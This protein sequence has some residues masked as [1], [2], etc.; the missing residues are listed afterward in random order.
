MWLILYFCLCYCS[1]GFNICRD[2]MNNA[3]VIINFPNFLS[4]FINCFTTFLRLTIQEK[5]FK[6]FLVTIKI[7]DL[8]INL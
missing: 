2:H 8:N 3:K 4:L 5:N 6:Q 1:T 7:L